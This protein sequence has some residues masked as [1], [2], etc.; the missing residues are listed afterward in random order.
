MTKVIL[1]W[2]LDPTDHLVVRGRDMRVVLV[3]PNPHGESTLP[4]VWIET[5]STE[6]PTEQMTLSFVGTGHPFDSGT[7]E[8]VGSAVCGPYVWHVFAKK[9]TLT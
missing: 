5:T 1:K 6:R 8:H 3:A 7:G 2:P 9:E 4:C